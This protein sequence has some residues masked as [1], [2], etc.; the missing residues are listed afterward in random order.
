MI[1]RR[2]RE[3]D[4]VAGQDLVADRS[5]TLA[6]YLADV[7][8]GPAALDDL[9]GA[10]PINVPDRQLLQVRG[11]PAA[12][13][14]VAARVDDQR[15]PRPLAPVFLEPDPVPG[16]PQFLGPFDRGQ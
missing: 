3:G 10:V 6:E 14:D 11:E 9:R 16:P 1:R 7:G 15:L 13:L 5:Q 12:R 8:V 4:R 2:G